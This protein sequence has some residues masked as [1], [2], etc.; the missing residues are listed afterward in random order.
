LLLIDAYDSFTHNLVHGLTL[1]GADVTVVR[2]DEVTADE[3]VAMAPRPIVFGPGPG[4]PDEAGCFV[5]ALRRLVGRAP[6]LGVCLGHQALARALGGHVLRHPPIHGAAPP[7]HHGGTGLFAGLPEA[8]PMTRYHSLVVDPA[9]LPKALEVTAWS[10]DGAILGAQHRTA[11]A[12]G[13]Q[14]H[15]ESVLSG[16]W[17]QRLLARFVALAR[18]ASAALEQSPQPPWHLARDHA[19]QQRT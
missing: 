3:L 11:P 19:E 13:V 10:D 7:V 2:C 8:V 9:T 5:P 15:P 12:W 1:A 18:D 6:V 16:A 14:F 17:G 4:T